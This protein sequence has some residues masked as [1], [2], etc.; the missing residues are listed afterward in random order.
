MVNYISSDGVGSRAIRQTQK[1]TNTNNINT[2]GKAI[3]DIKSTF[4]A[5][6]TWSIVGP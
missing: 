2:A 4:F 6:D 5:R 1:N 3:L